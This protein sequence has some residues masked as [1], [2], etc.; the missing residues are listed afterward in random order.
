M[1]P[2]FRDFAK[3]I[4]AVQDAY[5]AAKQKGDTEGMK[6]ALF[7][8]SSQPRLREHGAHPAWERQQGQ[9]WRAAGCQRPGL[10]VKCALCSIISPPPHGELF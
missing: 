4:K 1:E 2:S 5:T 7:Q 3:A 10:R 8:A 9:R 6:R